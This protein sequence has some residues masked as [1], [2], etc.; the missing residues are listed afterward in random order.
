MPT[1]KRVENAV[2]QAQFEQLAAFRYRLRLFLRFSEQ[3]A[4][5]EGVTPIQYQLL[6]Q[7]RGLP[8]RDWATVGELAE[9]L[10]VR[11][12]AVVSLVTRCESLSLVRRCASPTDGRE[13]HVRLQPKGQRVLARLAPLHHAELRA[14]GAAM[15]PVLPTPPSRR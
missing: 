14:L 8:G 11:H 5:R 10:Q 3:V 15:A 1:S 4:R 7:I 6:L 9:R 2:T 12:N 13:V